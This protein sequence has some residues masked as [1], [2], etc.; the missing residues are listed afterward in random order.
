[1]ASKTAICKKCSNVI[2]EVAPGRWGTR[3]HRDA[4]TGLRLTRGCAHIPVRDS[5]RPAGPPD[6]GQAVSA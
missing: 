5:V 2:E 4:N 3:A 1:V 6:S